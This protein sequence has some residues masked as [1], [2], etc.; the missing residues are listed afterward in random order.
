MILVLVV[1]QKHILVR[2]EQQCSVVGGS[3][4]CI[5][6]RFQ[7]SEVVSP[8]SLFLCFFLNYQSNELL[9]IRCERR[10]IMESLLIILFAPDHGNCIVLELVLNGN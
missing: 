5:F 2:Q 6:S 10:K 9:L 4:L 3:F 7:C 8:F 1:S